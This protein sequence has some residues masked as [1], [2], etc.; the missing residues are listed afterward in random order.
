MAVPSLVKI[1]FIFV[2][3]L[4]LPDLALSKRD[5]FRK[6]LLVCFYT[7]IFCFGLLFTYYHAVLNLSWATYKEANNRYAYYIV[8][9]VVM[10]DIAYLC[11]DKLF[12]NAKLIYGLFFVSIVL[13]TAIGIVNFMV[14]FPEGITFARALG[15][16]ISSRSFMFNYSA[17]HAD[18]FCVMLIVVGYIVTLLLPETLRQST[19][20]VWIAPTAT[21]IFFGCYFIILQS[22][23]AWLGVFLGMLVFFALMLRH[24]KWKS[25]FYTVAVFSTIM[26]LTYSVMATRIH[27]TFVTASATNMHLPERP[28][29]IRIFQNHSGLL[30]VVKATLTTTNTAKEE[31]QGRGKKSCK[32]PDPATQLGFGGT[33]FGWRYDMTL[34][35]L[36]MVSERPLLGFGTYNS[37]S[38][39][40]KDYV[41]KKCTIASHKHLHNTYL[42]IAVQLGIIAA[43]LML[44]VLIAPIIIALGFA[45]PHQLA[46]RAIIA[47]YYIYVVIENFFDDS[48][49]RNDGLLLAH[50]SVALFTSF[51]LIPIF[52]KRFA[53]HEDGHMPCQR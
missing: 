49:I 23:G 8:S 32:G 24:R 41:I 30:P 33:S 11:R 2:L 16:I 12:E 17:N 52:E 36:R 6:I 13:V 45:T 5:Q 15:T 10:A 18:D 51:L 31:D 19:W 48:L 38:M 1:I 9:L 39:A 7:I 50:L 4:F 26:A 27:E 47:V 28:D 35:G 22:R 42:Q 20:K 29:I 40:Q 21:T 43:L 37:N 34:E 53:N 44:T 46:M 14:Q 3:V 25:V